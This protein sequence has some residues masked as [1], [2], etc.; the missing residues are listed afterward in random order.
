MS[1]KVEVM[2]RFR[3]ELVRRPKVLNELRPGEPRLARWHTLKSNV[4]LPLL[5]SHIIN[6]ESFVW[7]PYA[8]DLQNWKQPV[9]YQDSEQI[10]SNSLTLDDD[11]QFF[12]RFITPCE[13]NGLGCKAK[14]HPHRVAMQLG[15]D[16]DVPGGQSSYKSS[17]FDK[18]FV[19]SRLYQPGVSKRY[20]DWWNNAGQMNVQNDQD[21][22]IRERM[23]VLVECR[24]FEQEDCGKKC[25]F[26]FV[27]LSLGDEFDDI[28][29]S[30]KKICNATKRKIDSLKESY[31]RLE[32][33]KK[34]LGSES[35]LGKND[36][37]I[38]D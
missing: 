19:P 7:R 6:L 14:Y 34:K 8:V 9:Y 37:I 26:E 24:K 30:L 1:E 3:S 33:C 2:N 5:H 20:F 29:M 35:R 25:D 12:V 16:Q 18:F 36:V 23:N 38:I 13:L 10:L 22:S 15:F 11:L 21:S 17:K 31:V 27:D 28:L 4:S 32:H